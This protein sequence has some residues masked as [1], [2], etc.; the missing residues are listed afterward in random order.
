MSLTRRSRRASPGDAPWIIRF[1]PGLTA[2]F[3]L[4]VPASTP[5][6]AAVPLP[7][8]AVLISTG[9]VAAAVIAWSRARRAERESRRLRAI[10][11]SLPFDL[12]ACDREGRYV[13]QNA[14]SLQHWGDQLGRKPDDVDL[15]DRTRRLW[16]EN[17][18]R[19]LGGELVTGTVSYTFDGERREHT[20]LLGPLIEDEQPAGL[21]G[22][23]VG[24][25]DL[26]SALTSAEEFERHHA[27]LNAIFYES[28]ETII[29]TDAQR[30]IRIVN[31]AFKRLFGYSEE[32]VIGQN[33]R[34]LYVDQGEYDQVGR[35]YQKRNSSSGPGGRSYTV[36]F[37]KRDGQ[38]FYAETITDILRDANGAQIGDVGL[39]RD[40]TERMR[41]EAEYRD[42][43]NNV[44]EGLCRSTPDGR[45]LRANPSLVRLFGYAS[46]TE[47]IE[48][49]TDVAAQC[50]VRAED[51]ER[52][53]E[54]LARDGYVHNYEVEMV[55]PA[56]GE[57]IW[58]SEN[59]HAVRDENGE[60]LY[61]DV[62]LEDITDRKHAEQEL[63]RSEQ[64]Y[65]GL[66]ER[67]P[68]MLHTIDASGRLLAVSGYW[69]EHLGYREDEVLGRRSVEFLTAES[70]R[71]AL[72]NRL[73]E[74]FRT[75]KVHEVPFQVVKADGSVIDVLLSAVAEYDEEGNL[76]RG[77]A[78]MSDVT[79]QRR[80][81]SRLREAAAVFANTADGVFIT[82]PAGTVRDVNRAFT[83]ITGYSRDDAIGANPRM[84]KSDHH[85]HDFYRA[86]W[87]S[88]G[89]HGHWR[90]E[91]W[92]RRKDGSVYPAWLTVSQVLSDE[93]LLNGYVAV[94]SDISNVKNAEA[95]LD[96]LAHHDSLTDL[97]NRLLLNDRLEHAIARAKRYENSL[98]LV[99]IDL[100]RFKHVNDSLG[101]T[102]G[103]EL[104]RQAGERLSRCLRTD[105][106]VARIGG[107]EFTLLLEDIAGQE[108][109]VVVAEK[110]LERFSE[111]FDLSGHDDYLSPSLGIALHPDNGDDA[112]TLLRN[113]DAA[114]YQAK[115]HGGNTFAFYTRSLTERAYERVQLEGSLRRALERDQFSLRY[116][117]QVDMVTGRV[118]GAEALLRWEH[119]EMG[120]IG[121]GRFI[122]IAEE[123]GTIVPIGTWVLRRACRDVA[124][125][126]EAGI[127]LERIA[128]NVAGPQIRR[129]DLVTAVRAALEGSGLDPWRLELEVTESFIMEQAER[130]LAVL[131]ELRELGVR[132]AIDD[133]GTGYSSLA[134]L[135][136]LPIDMLKIDQSFVRDVPDDANN[137]G[138]CR[139][140]IALA[141]NLDLEV[142]AEGVETEA[143]QEF[144]IA[145]GCE[146]AQGFRY[147]PPMTAA[148]LLEWCAAHDYR[149]LTAGE[150]KP[151]PG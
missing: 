127:E 61:L 31:P 7:W 82:D 99:F 83:Q 69:L 18:R 42:I 9:A 112:D 3:P 108:G 109:C 90:G 94:F 138:I 105:D 85:E 50:Y 52:M 118:V 111:P 67:T 130:S 100:D 101:H 131:N 71:D 15:D 142:L 19:A 73:P 141:M 119:P 34:M 12:W 41:A 35:D 95:R 103:D 126:L 30:R 65:R 66:Y 86:M 28:P 133:F 120:L 121:P 146:R 53:V 135:K 97:P 81:E 22:L 143:Q 113:A 106:T 5:V 139:A 145:G 14:A 150:A 64:R 124:E 110:V 47:V 149:P 13:F 8:L 54:R 96:H 23:N 122:P 76:D 132:L 98:A 33:T 68:V 56:N 128:V 84:W 62:S 117:P 25:P 79:E 40:V 11:N 27:L 77:L 51:R 93:G 116:Q 20:N 57:R 21:V 102:L 78:V 59:A 37:R 88:I 115:H 123:T 140:V 39:I 2:F 38:E 75:G 49:V 43:F 92:N 24:I 48:S 58:V 16:K 80:A 4:S 136:R 32:E 26:R 151:H 114:M 6:E 70:R 129:G 55:R 107:D 36:R 74:F 10:A 63:A 134:Y 17:N 89:E 148:D 137:V 87:R 46:E 44:A 91:I 29:A 60:L 125:W 147:S 1:L 72:Q 144:L 45:I 104:L